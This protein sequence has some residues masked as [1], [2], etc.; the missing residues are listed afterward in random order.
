MSL[1]LRVLRAY[2]S[3]RGAT[4][5]PVHWSHDP[6]KKNDPGWHDR[7]RALFATPN[8]ADRELEIDFG[9]WVGALAY[10]NFSA[11]N[12]ARGLEPQ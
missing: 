4:V 3:P 12:R 8:E 1:E 2:P 11:V 10:P 7:A 9:S 5:V 6:E